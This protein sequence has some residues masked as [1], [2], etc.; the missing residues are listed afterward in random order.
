MLF[1]ILILQ[2]MTLQQIKTIQY[3]LNVK[4]T[5]LFYTA[6]LKLSGL[7]ATPWAAEAATWLPLV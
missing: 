7:M 6:A 1:V 2:G 3:G 4:V 5:V